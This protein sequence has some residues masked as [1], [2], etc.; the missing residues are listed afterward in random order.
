M[1]KAF[2]IPKEYK[3]FF[4]A[5]VVDDPSGESDWKVVADLPDGVS[6]SLHCPFCHESLCT[7]KE[8]IIQADPMRCRSCH[9]F[10]AVK[11]Q[12]N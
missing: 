9:Q 5:D 2:E 1:R 6:M 4:I 3:T 8:H 7:T 12:K 10:F 11:L